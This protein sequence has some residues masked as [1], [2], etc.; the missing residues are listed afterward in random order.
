MAKQS[1]LR[2]HDMFTNTLGIEHVYFQPPESIKLQYPCIVYSRV[3]A[4][5]EYASNLPYKFNFAYQVTYIS[6]DPDDSMVDNILKLPM[7]RYDRSFKSEDMNHDV[8]RIYI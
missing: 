2:L 1:R 5:T 3:N 8:F 6:Y 7:C 4:D